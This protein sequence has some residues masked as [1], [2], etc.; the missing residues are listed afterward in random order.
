MA[1]PNIPSYGKYISLIPDSGIQFVDIEF[2]RADHV[3]KRWLF[4][5]ADHC[6]RRDEKAVGPDRLSTRDED[7]D[8]FTVEFRE[9]VELFE[10]EWVPVPFLHRKNKDQFDQGPTN[11]VRAQLVP[12]S[13]EPSS[14]ALKFRLVLA[15]DT[16]TVDRTDERY[17]LAPCAA[18]A[19]AGTEFAVPGFEDNSGPYF[20]QAWLRKWSKEL[21]RKM[22]ERRELRR[23]KLKVSRERLSDEFV[24][25]EMGE[26]KDHHV[27]IYRAFVDLLWVLQNDSPTDR[28][29]LPPLKMEKSNHLA[30]IDVTLV[31]DLGNSRTC[32][33][34][35]ETDSAGHSVD[36][37]K[38]DRL[39]LRDLSRPERIYADPFPSRFVFADAS[40]GFNAL[41][42]QTGYFEAFRWPSNVRIGCEAEWLSGRRRHVHGANGLSSPK[43]YL[44]D[45]DVQ[46]APWRTVEDGFA[47][48]V[49]TTLL[50]NEAGTPLH[51]LKP[52]AADG[53]PAHEGRYA[54]RNLTSLA[55]AE[56]V[57]QAL[58]MMNSPGH[59]H[60]K[61]HDYTRPRRLRTLIMT[62]PTAMP[63]AERAILETQ[64]RHAVELAF[65]AL[66]LAQADPTAQAP[67]ERLV[68]SPAAQIKPGDPQAG[69]EVKLDWDEATATQ[70]VFL[71]TQVAR[72]YS[73]D[74][75]AFFDDYRH[76]S[77]RDNPEM[78]P[79]TLRL[80]T[81]DI[82]GGTTDLVIA[83]VGVEGSGSNVALLPR[84]EFRE[85]F[86]LAGD[87]A[88]LA[89]IKACLLTPLESMLA[90][91]GASQGTVSGLVMRLFS[92]AGGGQVAEL[93]QLRQQFAAQVAAPA[94][95]A[96]LHRYEGYDPMVPAAPEVIKLKD[97]FALGEFPQA[98]ADEVARQCEAGGAPGLDLADLPVPIDFAAIDLLVRSVFE[99]SLKALGE[100]IHRFRCDVLI[101][102]GRAS[103][104]PAVRAMLIENS[105]LPAH[106]VV[107]M[108][109]LD[110]R[111]WYP[112]P[113]VEGTIEDPKTTAAVGAVVCH[114]GG[115]GQ[116]SNFPFRVGGLGYRST[117]RFFG[118]LDNARSHLP[119]ADVFFQNLQLQDREDE[120]LEGKPITFNAAMPL[121]FR[122]LS[123]ER[124]PATQLYW[125]KFASMDAS[126]KFRNRLPLSVELGLDPSREFTVAE[127]DDDGKVRLLN[128][129]LRVR[130]IQDSEG[131]PVPA[132]VLRLRLQTLGDE[133]GD[134]H[135]MDTGVLK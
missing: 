126:E 21:Y 86:K 34:I 65:L 131:T 133:A 47:V 2:Q 19:K 56:V 89:V 67:Q 129:R 134:G 66:G 115:L 10:R 38:T 61:L 35:T 77:N 58:S 25:L 119:H 12:L 87:D 32:G 48:D 85:G 4:T 80:A 78:P 101:L 44:W 37:S 41:S 17:Y 127:E 81:I 117:A 72:H 27:A 51:R 28:I 11:W 63:V 55:L 102:S 9:V 29:A 31:L 20:K 92:G 90:A 122:Q 59:R 100:V 24:E 57:L 30:P 76:P 99:K 123:V 8:G 3:P 26:F 64:T 112:F 50:I 109:G 110:V 42:E 97:L 95:I 40:F 69:P 93:A 18:D 98:V 7:A 74:A 130:S 82:G 52:D 23:R 14:Q 53:F 36:W 33:L 84:H 106:R 70:A 6:I 107:P 15:I 104:L 46:P 60:A 135:W 124:W 125:L 111:G 91:R 5:D 96:V 45:E 116:L 88:L 121:G 120:T 83:S 68:W 79:D 108:H 54:R 62:T 105:G 118:K 1:L 39:Q 114:L 94:A 113:N 73:G 13:D 49:A 43:R 22:L 132:S 71:Y 103:R 128:P 75:R 16:R